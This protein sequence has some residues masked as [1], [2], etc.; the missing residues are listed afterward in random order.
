MIT[1]NTLGVAAAAAIG[2]GLFAALGTFISRRTATAIDG[3]VVPAD[4][5]GLADAAGYDV[6]VYA[7]ARVGASEAG[8]QKKI[9]K[10]GVMWVVMN[11]ANRRSVNVLDVILGDASSF[12]PQGTGG[13]HFVSSSHDPQTIDFVTAQ[14]VSD[15]SIDDPTG[16]ALNF[17]SPGAYSDA[18]KA[19]TFAANRASEGKELVLLEGV[20]EKTFRFWRPA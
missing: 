10:A 2:A 15:G 16:G 7:L 9:A 4:V 11:E 19:D 20:A 8:G 1:A 12:G 3:S 13:R 18:A 6:A 5:Q 14:G 17:D